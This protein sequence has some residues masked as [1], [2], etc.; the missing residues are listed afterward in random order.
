[1]RDLA[2]LVRYISSANAS[3]T[4]SRRRIAAS[5]HR[6]TPGNSY[7]PSLLH[8]SSSFNDLMTSYPVALTSVTRNLDRET[9]FLSQGRFVVASS[10]CLSSHPL[11]ILRHPP[12]GFDS[13]SKP[14]SS[15][16]VPSRF[17]PSRSTS[18]R[19]PFN[20][21]S[22]KRRNP[23]RHFQPDEC[24]L[25][26]RW[27]SPSSDRQPSLLPGGP[28]RPFSVHS[29]LAVSRATSDLTPRP[30]KAA[31]GTLGHARISLCA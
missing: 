7:N 4:K 31:T 12:I 10:P 2:A 20:V 27:S 8:L 24:P 6:T 19:Q 9:R 11:R 25:P 30:G 22:W 29:H 17:V 3:Q 23:R 13:R 1:M 28:L 5:D 21:S 16:S 18:Y 14:L 26:L 15:P